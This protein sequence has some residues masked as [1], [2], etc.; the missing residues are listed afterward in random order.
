MRGWWG[1]EGVVEVLGEV[2]G[3]RRVIRIGRFGIVDGKCGTVHQR[4]SD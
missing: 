1:V 2:G 3:E 4:L